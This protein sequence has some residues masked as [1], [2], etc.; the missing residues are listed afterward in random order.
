MHTRK[1]AF[2]ALAVV[3]FVAWYAFRPEG[4]F[5]NRRVHEEMPANSSSKVQV[6]ESG[7]FYGIAHPTEGTATIYRMGDSVLMLRFTNFKTT[8]GPNVH[9][10]LV[11]A[12]DAKDNDVVRHSDFIDLGPIKGNIGDRNYALGSDLDLSKYRSVSIWCKR[13]SLNFGVASLKPDHST[14]QNQVAK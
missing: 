5:I 9:V 11:A 4:L 1:I 8:N 14:S 13:F 10:Y 3:L 2:A 7:A 12:D 6:I